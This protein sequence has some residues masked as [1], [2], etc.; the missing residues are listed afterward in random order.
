MKKAQLQMFETAMVLLFFFIIVAFGLMF[1]VGVQKGKMDKIKGEADSITSVEIALAALDF[2]EL[3][4]TLSPGRSEGI[5]IDEG[6]IDIVKL[7][8]FRSYI[9]DP[10]N[11]Y[12]AATY[13]FSR[14]QFSKISVKEIYPGSSATIVYS[15][16][17]KM[18]NESIK[19]FN[20]PVAL[21]NPIK[22]SYALGIL[23]VKVAQ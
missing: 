17:N 9:T 16:E 22:D 1:Y 12:D 13:Y 7:E 5:V 8:A 23:E 11:E 6:C 21:Y 19:T 3:K 15:R 2:P 18:S 14:L 10:V 4:C 20:M